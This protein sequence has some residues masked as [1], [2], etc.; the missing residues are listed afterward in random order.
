MPRSKDEHQVGMR[1]EQARPRLKESGFLAFERAARDEETQ[2]GCT[3]LEQTGGFGFIG[4]ADIELEVSGDRNA[5]GAAADGGEAVGIGLTLR[6]DGREMGENGSPEAPQHL[7]AR[8][9]AVGDAGVDAGILPEAAAV[10]FDEAHELEEVASSYFGLSVSNIRFEEL[11]R[12]TDTLLRA[13]QGSARI[14]AATQQLRDRARMFFA[15]LPMNGDGRQPFSAREE[16]LETSGDLYMSV[17]ATLR[18][19]EA[20]M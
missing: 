2:A 17:Q 14:P 7:I 10:V 6:Q 4:G 1:S 12:D 5:L 8:P 11:A 19:I 16:F 20:E 9:G 3:G 15:N 13:K 18:R